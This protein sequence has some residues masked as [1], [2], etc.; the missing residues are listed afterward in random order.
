MSQPPLMTPLDLPIVHMI[1]DNPLVY[2]TYDNQTVKVIDYVSDYEFLNALNH[3]NIIKPLGLVPY[4]GRYYMVLPTLVPVVGPLTLHQI[5]GLFSAL[6]YL[7]G[8]N[9]SRG[10]VHDGPSKSTTNLH[11]C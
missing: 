8:L 6:E 4:M 11:R 5:M 2:H 3:D 9:R 1:Q 7:H 10:D